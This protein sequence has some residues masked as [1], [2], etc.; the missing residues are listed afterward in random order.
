MNKLYKIISLSNKKTIFEALIFFFFLIILFLV[1]MNL[2]AY[3]LVLFNF[4]KLPMAK[5]EIVSQIFGDLFKVALSIIILVKK[6]Q[7]YGVINI[8]LAILLI[9]IIWTS[10]DYIL[11]FLIITFFT[12]LKNKT[13][14]TNIENES[15]AES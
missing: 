14:K 7:I 12:F 3:S 6:R 4:P 10:D 9:L 8:F 5:A 15:L 1:Y 13:V 11:S 2:I